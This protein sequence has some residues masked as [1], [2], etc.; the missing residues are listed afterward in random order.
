MKLQDI[1]KQVYE[2]Q[3]YANSKSWTQQNLYETYAFIS[4]ML[5]PDDAYNYA[6]FG[7]G[8]WSYKDSK[9]N[10]YYVRLAYVPDLRDEYNSY[11]E[12]KTYWL[13]NG[14]AQ[15]SD[16]RPNVSTIDLHKRSNTVAKIYRD[17]IVPFFK[18]QNLS[19]IIKIFPIDSARYRLSKMMVKKYTPEDLNVSFFDDRIQIEK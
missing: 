2:E 11:L 14:K 15:Y 1:I 5:N 16:F 9:D 7:K 19:N 6:A 8:I 18:S 4:E 17:E 12:L 3:S 10:E 13:Q